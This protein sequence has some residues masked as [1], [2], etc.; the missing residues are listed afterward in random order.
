M[1][2]EQSLSVSVSAWD[3]RP[4]AWEHRYR[5]AE[6]GWGSVDSG[7]KKS[8]ISIATAMVWPYPVNLG[9]FLGEFEPG[10]GVGGLAESAW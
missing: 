2:D 10:S 9:E 3:D 7:Q 6:A 1:R 4:C 5:V 8:G